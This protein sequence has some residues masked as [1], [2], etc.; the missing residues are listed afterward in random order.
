MSTPA[1]AYVPVAATCRSG[2]DESVHF[3]TAVAIDA[4]GSVLWAAGEPDVVIY[5]RSSNKPMQADAMLGLGVELTTEQLALACASHDGTQRHLDVVRGTLAAAGLDE[6]ALGNTPGLPLD[7]ASAEALLA[8]GGRRTPLAMN[9]SGK[10]AAMLATCVRRGWPLDGYLD[11]EH[12][13]QV[14]ITQRIVE[15][16]GGVAHIGV[17]GCG[18]PAHA[19][20]LTAL[21]HAF[22]ELATSRSAVWAAMTQHPDLVGGDGTDTTSLMRAVPG[23]M[24][25]IGA[26]GV[27][28]AALPAGVA[29]A[30]KIA[31]GASRAAGVVTAAALRAVGV[32]VTDGVVGEPILGHGRPV[33]SV[34][35][36]VGA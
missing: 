36:L 19:M 35:A 27:F 26:E 12:P 8:A 29:V 6:S 3:G 17:D 23:L 31:D 9:C 15:L 34:R 7:V 30:V 18:A 20:S 11:V 13:L 24:A 10:H 1:G 32:D 16:S 33:G 14:A 22:G 2:F 5:P 25:K 4:G 28:A 21:A